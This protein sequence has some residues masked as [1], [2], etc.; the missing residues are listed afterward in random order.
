MKSSGTSGKRSSENIFE[1]SNSLSKPTLCPQFSGY[2]SDLMIT[3]EQEQRLNN[4]IQDA[5]KILDAFGNL[6]S[7]SHNATRFIYE[8]LQNARDQCCQGKQ[9][10]VMIR[11]TKDDFT[12]SHNG[13]P[14]K[15][16]D[17]INVI[18]QGSN[19]ERP[20]QAQPSSVLQELKQPQN[21]EVSSQDQSNSSKNLCILIQNL[22][23]KKNKGNPEKETYP[24]KCQFNISDL[25]VPETTGKYGTGLLTTYLLSKNL[26][27]NGIL[28]YDKQDKNNFRKFRIELIRDAQT[29]QE[30]MNQIKQSFD[31]VEIIGNTDYTLLLSNYDEGLGLDT[32]FSYLLYKKS[33]MKKA[34]EAIKSLLESA[35]FVLAFNPKISKITI[36]DQTTN[37]FINLK[38]ENTPLL[39][40]Q[41]CH[42]LNYRENEVLKTVLIAYGKYSCAATL[43][44]QDQQGFLNVCKLSKAIPNIF[45]D[46][47]LIGSETLGSSIVFNSHYFDTNEKRTGIP[48]SSDL[49]SEQNKVVI[50]ECIILYENILKVILDKGFKGVNHLIINSSERIEQNLKDLLV[51][52]CIKIF[53][54]NQVVECLIGF[55]KIGEVLFPDIEGPLNQNSQAKLDHLMS[56]LVVLNKNEGNLVKHNFDYIKSWFDLFE[57]QD[58]KDYSQKENHKRIQSVVDKVSSFKQS[59]DF[60][61]ELGMSNQDFHKFMKNLYEYLSKYC[62]TM[63]ISSHRK[64]SIFVNQNMQLR[65]IS[66]LYQDKLDSD[67]IKTFAMN[68]GYD[69]R[70]QMISNEFDIPNDFSDQIWNITSYTIAQFDQELSDYLK[71][72]YVCYKNKKLFMTSSDTFKINST[73]ELFQM[74]YQILFYLPSIKQNQVQEKKQLDQSLQEHL[75]YME[76]VKQLLGFLSLKAFPFINNSLETQIVKEVLIISQKIAINII[77]Q[78]IY[79]KLINSFCV[80]Q[81]NKSLLKPN[82]DPFEFLNRF[83]ETIKLTK[84]VHKQDHLLFNLGVLLNQHGNFFKK[85]SIRENK[86]TVRQYKQKIVIN[87]ALQDPAFES[88]EEV[89]QLIQFY[90]TFTDNSRLE[91]D[92]FQ[93]NQR[94]NLQLIDQCLK[95]NNTQKVSGQ[96][97]CEELDKSIINKCNDRTIQK[98]MEKTILL[99]DD[100][101]LHAFVEQAKCKVYFPL[102]EGIRKAV[103]VDIK[104]SGEFSNHLFEI[105]SQNRESSLG[106]IVNIPNE[107]YEMFMKML[108][109]ISNPEE[110]MKSNVIMKLLE[111][112]D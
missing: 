85:T 9:I 72:N 55:N 10:E 92:K 87:L 40:N 105:L 109:I 6:Q 69:I 11:L 63:E 36:D 102:Y 42:F 108:K 20:E 34:R 38:I 97:I 78:E 56:V 17:L 90:Y 33:Q 95:F 26:I 80:D 64:Q 99:F 98:S 21:L 52:P 48:L 29:V 18:K 30:M 46:Y 45:V 1:Q 66:V 50:K 91:D 77:L 2:S 110:T 83:Y 84:K 54:Q 3:Y 79:Y 71:K 53:T 57:K 104:Q 58:W 68:F 93:V 25:K 101:Y 8:L 86:R 43:I 88:N 59:S 67:P 61:Q 39:L 60:Y 5:K 14:F 19:K 49:K 4:E 81:M 22:D 96:Q 89:D 70:S 94:L 31:Q 44:E 37:S 75:D 27:V 51:T 74:C 28:H 47:P 23:N 111:K 76:Q 100:F 41:N 62:T 107:R 112:F 103:L 7:E 16:N 65:P 24:Q 82:V 106:Y 35:P 73:N 15:F 32:S 13:K 12:F